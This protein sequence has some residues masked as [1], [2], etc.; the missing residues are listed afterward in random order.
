MSLD[1]ASRAAFNRIRVLGEF[2]TVV[3]GIRRLRD[4]GVP[5]EINF[6]PTRFN[7]GEIGSAVD[8]AY[9]LGAVQLLHRAHDVHRQCGQGVASS[10]GRRR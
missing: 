8:L 3:A 2:D 4:A 6:S 10:R 7:V 9:E 1:G 5:I